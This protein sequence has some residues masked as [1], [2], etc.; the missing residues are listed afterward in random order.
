MEPE[1]EEM[2]NDLLDDDNDLL[3]AWEVE[4]TDSLAGQAGSRDN[5]EPSDRQIEVLEK[6]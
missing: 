4:F 1:W 6:I 3:T 2:L 5:W